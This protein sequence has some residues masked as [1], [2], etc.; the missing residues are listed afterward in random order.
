MNCSNVLPQVRLLQMHIW[1]FSDPV[2]STSQFVKPLTF[3]ESTSY[4]FLTGGTFPCTH[5]PLKEYPWK[6]LKWIK[7]R[8][9]HKISK[10]FLSAGQLTRNVRV[11]WKEYHFRTSQLKS[12]PLQERHNRALYFKLNSLLFSRKLQFNLPSSR[13]YGPPSW[14]SSRL[15]F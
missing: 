13:G 14:C 9:R 2:F 15:V 12:S 10:K 8:K 11:H 3:L 5:T 7:S 4:R 6:S 1:Q